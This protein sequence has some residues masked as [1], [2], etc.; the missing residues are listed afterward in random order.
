MSERRYATGGRHGQLSES[1]PRGHLL[2]A[3]QLADDSE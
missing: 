3:V 1:S 2:F